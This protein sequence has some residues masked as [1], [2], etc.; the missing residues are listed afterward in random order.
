MKKVLV[1]SLGLYFGILFFMPKDSLFFTLQKELAKK[2]IFLTAQTSLT[3]STLNLD[4][5]KLYYGKLDIAT[6]K[7]G[8]IYPFLFLNIAHIDDINLSLG[9]YT[10]DRVSALHTLL[11]PLKIS[12]SGK[13]NFG[14]LDGAID[15]ARHELKL[16]VESPTPD[17]KPYLRK[18]TQGYYFYAKF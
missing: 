11:H 5:M 1:A 18:D 6:A 12:L 4:E 2:N 17:I 10:I 8:A 13:S 9:N 14:S 3:P 7:T 16:Y 15:L